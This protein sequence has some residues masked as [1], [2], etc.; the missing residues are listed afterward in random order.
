MSRGCSCAVCYSS[1][2]WTS[3][4]IPLTS[5]ISLHFPTL[6][7]PDVKISSF[8]WSFNAWHM[9]QLHFTHRVLQSSSLWH[10]DKTWRLEQWTCL[11]KL[12]LRKGY[13]GLH[14]RFGSLISWH[15]RQHSRCGSLISWHRGL[16]FN[17]CIDCILL[18][19]A[20]WLQ[21][22]HFPWTYCFPPMQVDH[23]YGRLHIPLWDTSDPLTV[24]IMWQ[25]WMASSA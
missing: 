4:R 24:C 23:I 15:G 9:F 14:S 17:D 21:L 8:Q 3:F 1:P 25:C 10:Y 22:P 13:L 16:I 6:R 18:Q 5:R 20:S 11:W 19:F 2:Y 12:L 7:R